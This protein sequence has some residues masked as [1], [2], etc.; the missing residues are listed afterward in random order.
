VET[1]ENF[2]F[3][4]I[5]EAVN[6]I[7]VAEMPNV[8]F[9]FGCHSGRTFSAA[10]LASKFLQYEIKSYAFDSFEG[11]PQTQ[12]DEDGIFESGTYRT[13]V[14]RFKTIIKKKTGI[15]LKDD[16]MIKGYYEDSLNSKLKLNLP[17]KI[18]F[19]HIDVDLYSSTV[20][21][22]EFLKDYLV[23]GTVVLFDDWYCFAPGKEMGE[24]KALNE[25]LAKYPSIEF[26][27]WK[28]YSTFGKS[29]FVKKI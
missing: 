10:L 1:D 27:E 4:H 15:H 18:G 25:F 20:T 5:L 22:L 12:K 13:E 3:I 6:Y 29:F 8:F 28:N 2:K 23:I 9:E 11:L 21:V 26:E 16:Q 24:R 17:K 14:K 19:V 7:R